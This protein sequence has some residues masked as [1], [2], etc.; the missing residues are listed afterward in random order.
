[1]LIE[2][3]RRPVI[4]NEIRDKL[5]EASIYVGIFGRQLRDW[6]KDEFD[7]AKSSSLPQLIYKYERPSGPGRPP[8]RR[9]V[10]RKTA[11]QKFLEREAYGPGIRVNGP[12]HDLD[13]LHTV[14]PADIA[15][16]VA[17]MARENADIRRTLYQGIPRQT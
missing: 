9:R 2:N 7:Y 5:D 14:I 16:V 3:Q 11:V 8:E 12:Y 6:V 4:R 17:E 13:I 1:V 10:G 15:I